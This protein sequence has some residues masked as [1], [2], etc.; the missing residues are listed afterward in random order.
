MHP[1]YTGPFHAGSSPPFGSSSS[2][3]TPGSCYCLQS[4]F[5]GVTDW[6]CERR[7]S[8]ASIVAVSCL[9]RRHACSC[10]FADLG[11][12]LVTQADKRS[13]VAAGGATAFAC[14]RVSRGAARWSRRLVD[15]RRRHNGVTSSQ[16]AGKHGED[17]CDRTFPWLR[18]G[19]CK[20]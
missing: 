11:A 16:V 7:A 9:A 15:A 6:R 19:S 17:P 10:K 12:H 18:V 3:P 4:S 8:A 20:A 14:V 1:N 13:A 5:W 2:L